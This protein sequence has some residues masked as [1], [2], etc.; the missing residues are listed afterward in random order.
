MQKKR[1]IKYS[2]YIKS[3]CLVEKMK[4]INS[5]L[6]INSLTCKLTD[7]N[8]NELIKDKDC[9]IDCV[10]NIDTRFLMNKYCALN[11]VPLVSGSLSGWE[12]QVT[13][14]N[15]N[16][17]PCYECIV[18]SNISRNYNSIYSFI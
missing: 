7:D 1:D 16:N 6:N 3:E 14:Y 2:L 9:V 18:P 13:V 5:E 12:G 17:G 10:D 4:G 15:Y 8:A 11:N